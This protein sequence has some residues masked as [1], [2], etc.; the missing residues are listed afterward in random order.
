MDPRNYNNLK[1]Y[2]ETLTIP[3]NWFPMLL[4][5]RTLKQ[6]TTKHT[7]FDLTYR[8]TAT[9]PINFT[10]ETYSVQPINKKNF[11]ET[12][13]KRAYTFLNTLE[14]KRHIAASYI[15]HFQA[16]QK[17][18][19]DNKLPPVTNEFKIGNKVFLHRTKAEKQ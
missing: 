18:R 13:Q 8:R 2:L 7:P 17:E 15:K 1:N 5:Y 12:L 16:L 3:E 11:Q 14:E 6:D 4:A 9:L 19:H 10:V